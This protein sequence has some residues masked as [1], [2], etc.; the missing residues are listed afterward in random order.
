MFRSTAVRCV[1]AATAGA[2]LRRSMSVAM[3]S[4]MAPMASALRSYSTRKYTADHE[5]VQVNGNVATVGISEY[6]QKALGDV[7]YVEVPD[8]GANLN[9]K[10]VL[11]AV[12]SVK[13]A[14]DV[15]APISGKVL[16]VNTNLADE[17]SLI[18]KSPY[19]DG[20]IA[21]LEIADTTQLADLMD[22]TAYAA[23][24]E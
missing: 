7:V 15:Y 16:S 22:E 8:V 21:K 3:I 20:W 9:R 12:E 10:D 18:N 2:S 24:I 1:A 5:W 13:A 14:S 17:P 4:R 19:A 11:S 6:A 23:H